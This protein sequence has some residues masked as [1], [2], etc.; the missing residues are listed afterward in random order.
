MTTLVKRKGKDV[1][2]GYGKYCFLITKDGLVK[3]DC[4]VAGA[5]YRGKLDELEEAFTEASYAYL[6]YTFDKVEEK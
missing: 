5:K 3:D 1:S 4:Q 2:V 6:T